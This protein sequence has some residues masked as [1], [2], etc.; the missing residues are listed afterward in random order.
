MIFAH[1]RWMTKYSSCLVVSGAV[2]ADGILYDE[3]MVPGSSGIP[4]FGSQTGRLA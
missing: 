2:S 4:D 3:C 1:A